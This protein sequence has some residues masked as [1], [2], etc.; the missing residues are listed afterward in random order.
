MLIEIR[1][2]C[3]NK[4]ILCG[5]YESIRDCLEKNRG[6]NLSWANL[7]IPFSVEIN[8]IYYK[9]VNISNGKIYSP[10]HNI[11]YEWKIGEIKKDTNYNGDKRLNCDG[12]LNLFTKIQALKWEGSHLLKVRVLDGGICVPYGSDGKFR[13]EC[14]EVL[15]LIDKKD[16][17]KESV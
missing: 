10:T 5:E 9:S 1:N 15:E 16:V 4:I 2:W 8:N 14:V 13:V 17:A 11:L 3:N 6:A 12:G 7:S